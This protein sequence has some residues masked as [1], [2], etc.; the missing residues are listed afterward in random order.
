MSDQ[1]QIPLEPV[2]SLVVD[3]ITDDVSDTYVSKTLFAVSEFSNVVRSGAKV[4]S[5][6]AL[7]CA[8]LGFGLRLKSSAHGVCHTMLFDTGPEGAIVLLAQV[9]SPQV[10]ALV[11]QILHDRDVPEVGSDHERRDAVAVGGVYIF[12]ELNQQLHDFQPF[13]GRPLFVIAIDKSG[14]AGRHQGG[15]LVG[16]L[17]VRIRAMSEQKFDQL[18]VARKCSTHQSGCKHDSWRA[19]AHMGSRCGVDQG[20]GVC[21]GIQK[22]LGK[23]DGKTA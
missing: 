16:R 7:L 4:I 11:D 18:D 3:V 1:S 23:P 22:L 12:A 8:N 2:D 14:P 21:S 6:E 15:F 5:G 20:I 19:L 13:G 17:N 10:S 9:M